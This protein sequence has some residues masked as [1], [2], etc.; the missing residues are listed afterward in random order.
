MSPPNTWRRISEKPLAAN[1]TQIQQSSH[2]FHQYN[3]L[4]LGLSATCVF[5]S[6]EIDNCIQ[7][8]YWSQSIVGSDMTQWPLF[9]CHTGVWQ[10]WNWESTFI[11]R[12]LKYKYKFSTVNIKMI[13]PNV[14]CKVCLTLVWYFIMEECP[15]GREAGANWGTFSLQLIKWRSCAKVGVLKSKLDILALNAWAL[16]PCNVS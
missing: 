10:N 8:K 14:Y 2:L 13:A 3:H 9:G 15:K 11:S 16:R 12:L 7:Y 1:S 4:S 6:S 5:Y